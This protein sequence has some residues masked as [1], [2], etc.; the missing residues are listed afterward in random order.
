MKPGYLSLDFSDICLAVAVFFLAVGL[1]FMLGLQLTRDFLVAGLRMFGQLFV[2]GWVLLWVFHAK[3]VWVSVGVALAMVGVAAYTAW[4]RVKSTQTGPFRPSPFP[5]LVAL[6][7]GVGLASALGIGAILRPV[8]WFDP[9]YLIPLVGMV[10]GNTMNV[11]TLAAERFVGVVVQDAHLIESLLAL[12][13]SAE[14][15]LE[16]HKRQALRV[17]LMPTLNTMMVVGV[18]SLPGMMTGQILAGASPNQAVRYQ[19]L[20]HSLILL[21]ALIVSF[22]SVRSLGKR[23]IVNEERLAWKA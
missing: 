4:S 18:V 7:C 14:K 23:L 11:S 16:S 3:S 1:Q 17:S 2:V 19:M 8:P 13:V 10:T 5:F 6:A 22:L 12:G 21:S 20:I 15:S 9:Q